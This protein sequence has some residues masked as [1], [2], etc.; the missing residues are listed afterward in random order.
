[1]NILCEITKKHSKCK[2]CGIK[3]KSGEPRLYFILSYGRFPDKIVTCKE[4]AMK[5]IKIQ[6]L[7]L[8]R[9][10]AETLKDGQKRYVD[11]IS[12]REVGIWERLT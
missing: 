8:G 5:T 4:Y 2:C 12:P 6:E 9:F 11:E 7:L 3:I 10:I 1:M